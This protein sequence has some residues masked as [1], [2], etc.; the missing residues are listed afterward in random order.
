MPKAPAPTSAADTHPVHASMSNVPAIESVKAVPAATAAE[1]PVDSA[2]KAAAAESTL[3]AAV[4]NVASV[5]ITGCLELDKETFWLKDTSGVDAPTSRSWR[6]GFLKKRWSR[7]E[8]VDATNALKL[9]NHIG[10]RQPHVGR[11]RLHGVVRM[12]L[13]R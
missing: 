3:N 4:E 5:T 2:P 8:L 7:I 12:A 9:P 11:S 10:Q 13:S 1:P 6:S